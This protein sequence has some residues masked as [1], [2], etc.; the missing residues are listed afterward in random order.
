MRGDG[1]FASNEGIERRNIARLP[2][3][4]I[5]VGNILRQRDLALLQKRH[6]SVS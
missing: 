2:T 5:G 6:T 3:R 4:R 1:D